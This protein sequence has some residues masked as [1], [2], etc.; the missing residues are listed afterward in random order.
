MLEWAWSAEQQGFST[1]YTSD[2]L[3]WS[4]FEP[5]TTLA[6]VAGAT[7]RIRLLAVVLAPLHANHALFASAT[8]S[9]D[10]LAGPGRLRLALA[11]GPRPDD[12]ERS[13]LGFRSRGKQ[14]DALLD[15]LH[16][17]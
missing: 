17:S 15:E 5:L 1:L 8:A 12:F 13:G 9:V 10:Q 7:T 14:L 11:P 6:A 2:R 4:S 3:M 16:T